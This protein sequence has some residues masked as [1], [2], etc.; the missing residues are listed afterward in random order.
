[1]RKLFFFVTIL[2]LAGWGSNAAEEEIKRVYLVASYTQE[3][4][5]GKPQEEGILRGLSKEGWF[6][7]MNLQ[8]ERYYMDTK[9]THTSPEAM[10]REGQNAL[11]GIAAFSPHVVVVLDDNAFR[12][13]ALPLAG[14]KDVSVVFSG[15]NGPPESYNE[16]CPFMQ[17]RQHPGGNITG[18]YEKLYINHSIRVIQRALPNQPGHK[19][20][21]IIDAT[22]TGKAL[23]KQFSLE[24]KSLASRPP[25][26]V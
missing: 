8:V 17:T 23:E 25:V 13:V 14:Q 18:V 9:G 12:E 2:L 5:C 16:Q 4:V 15:L 21:G 20:V 22:A 24:L 1:M 11:Q 26:G 6:E 10:K 3:D 19:I 7:G